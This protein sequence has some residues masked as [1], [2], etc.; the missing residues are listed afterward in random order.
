MDRTFSDRDSLNGA[1][2]ADYGTSI[3]PQQNPISILNL[4]VDTR[5]LSLGET[6]IFLPPW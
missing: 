6:H 2:T 3:T 5:V 1:F 4:I